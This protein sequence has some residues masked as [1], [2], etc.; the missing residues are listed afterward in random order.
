MA[1]HE[2]RSINI[3]VTKVFVI[4]VS[5]HRGL[6]HAIRRSGRYGPCME[7]TYGRFCTYIPS[8]EIHSFYYIRTFFIQ[9]LRLRLTKILR[10]C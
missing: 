7:I 3:N 5:S 4:S 1:I 2:S 10:K 9:T 8:T 6:K